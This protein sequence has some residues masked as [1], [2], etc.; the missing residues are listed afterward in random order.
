MTQHSPGNLVQSYG[1][2]YLFGEA[3]CLLADGPKSP[4]QIERSDVL[5]VLGDL[6][7][8]DRNKTSGLLV[9]SSRGIIG[10]A[11]EGWLVRG[12]P[13]PGT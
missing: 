3:Q 7:N 6:N 1:L 12:E 5:C 9:M 11:R 8:H 10:W 13:T 4:G 2:A